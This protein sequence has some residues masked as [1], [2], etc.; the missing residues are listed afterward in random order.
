MGS[1]CTYVT[2]PI[3]RNSDDFTCSLNA[4]GRYAAE[5]C[6]QFLLIG[7]QFGIS[8]SEHPI[9]AVAIMLLSWYRHR[10]RPPIIIG[11]RKF[12]RCGIISIRH[13]AMVDQTG[14]EPVSTIH[15]RIN[16]SYAIRLILLI[17]RAIKRWFHLSAMPKGRQIPFGDAKVTSLHHLLLQ[18]SKKLIVPFQSWRETYHSIV[19]FKIHRMAGNWTILKKLSSS[20]SLRKSGHKSRMKSNNVSVVYFEFAP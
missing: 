17:V 12:Q 13:T 14:I 19:E 5:T 20:S 7:V 3:N 18:R 1:N 9:P 10:M 15:T 4:S 2:Y 8:S 6:K 11:R 16:H